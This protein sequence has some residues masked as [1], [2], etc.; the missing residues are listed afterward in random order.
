MI[1]I[2]LPNPIVLVTAVPTLKHLVR[3]RELARR[4]QGSIPKQGIWTVL[5][6]AAVFCIST[7]PYLLYL[8]IAT[9]TV[10]ESPDAKPSHPQLHRITYFLGLLNIISN[11]YIYSRTIQSFRRFLL[12]YLSKAFALCHRI[13]GSTTTA[14][15]KSEI[16]YL[17]KT[18][19]SYHNL[20][21]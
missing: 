21:T 1:Y 12:A 13:L 11:F 16:Q 14:G 20:E 3:A 6:T 19:H 5:L 7:S 2:L 15:E 8:T 18:S 17:R 4:V 9:L 10:E